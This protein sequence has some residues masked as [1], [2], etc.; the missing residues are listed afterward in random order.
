MGFYFT[1]DKVTTQGQQ[2]S[3]EKKAIQLDVD[4]LSLRQSNPNAYLYMFLATTNAFTDQVDTVSFMHGDEQL[5]RFN[6]EKSELELLHTIYDAHYQRPPHIHFLRP[7]L[8]ILSSFFKD[9]SKPIAVKAEAKDV[10]LILNE[11]V[12]ITEAEYLNGSIDLVD[13]QIQL[14]INEEL[15]QIFKGSVSC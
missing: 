12:M 2:T 4:I 11:P 10:V 13:P 9:T 3:I 1:L 8:I 15:T 7:D 14:E 6:S 5:P